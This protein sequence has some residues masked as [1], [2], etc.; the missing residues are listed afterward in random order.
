VF[1]SVTCRVC[2]YCKD[3]VV[4]KINTEHWPLLTG[5]VKNIQ[6]VM[7]Y[8][9]TQTFLDWSHASP[10]TCRSEDLPKWS[11]AGVHLFSWSRIPALIKL[12]IALTVRLMSSVLYLDC[13]GFGLWT[14]QSRVLRVRHWWALF[15]HSASA[16]LL[17]HTNTSHTGSRTRWTWQKMYRA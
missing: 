17:F 1:Y 14:I 16:Q 11:P 15:Y 3:V 2:I 6:R 9:T 5:R 4:L 7:D 12:K 8:Q 10:K 13:I